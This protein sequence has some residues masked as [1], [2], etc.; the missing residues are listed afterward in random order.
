MLTGMLAAV[1]VAA[2]LPRQ[3]D[4]APVPTPHFPDAL[5]A[6]VW[7]NWQ[8]VEP[9]RL[10]KVLGT[11]AA[12][13]QD[14]AVSMGLPRY[15]VVPA[16]MKER[17]YITLVRRNWHL[18]PLE[19]IMQL[20]DVSAAEMAVKFREDDALSWKL[21]FVRPKCPPVIYHEPNAAARQRAAEIK[22]LVDAR[23][24]DRL[25]RDAEPRF[26]FVAELSGIPTAAPSETLPPDD[27]LRFLYSYFGVYGDPLSA[28]SL[29]PYP[30]GLL[31]R[32]QQCDVNGVW[33][34][35]LLRQLAPGGPLF[36]EFGEG[37]E[38]RLKNLR[39]MVDRARKYNI[40]V[41]LFL[42]EP[43]A[44]PRGFFTD[45]PELAGAPDPLDRSY[46]SICT[47]D[48][49]V[50][51]WYADS[52]SHVFREVP[53][54]GGVFTITASEMQS[55][56]ASHANRAECP[57]CGKR[58]AAEVIAELNGTVEAAVHGV[59][60]HAKV[61]VWDWGWNNHGDASDM[62]AASPL[63]TWLM[64]V[65]EWGVPIRRG[66]VPYTTGEYSL[67]A[68]GPGPRAI[69]HWAAARQ[70]GLKTVAKVQVSNSWELSAVPYLPVYDLVAEHGSRLA[71][72]DIDGQMLSWSLG[73]YPSPNLELAAA[74]SR[75]PTPDK[76]AAIQALATRHFGAA[77]APQVR[78]A[79]KAFSQAFAEFPFGG[80]VVYNAPQQFGPANLLYSTPTG[81]N[82]GPVCFPYDDLAHWSPP[83][84]KQV[85]AAQ[86]QK[87]ADGWN[88]GIA[89]LR[90]AQSEVPADKRAWAQTDLGVAEAAQI[91][92]AST[93]N[94]IRFIL[95]RDACAIAT[96]PA[97]RDRL[98]RELSLLLDDESR[99]ADR[100]FELASK[101]SRLG[102]EA[103]NHYYYVPLDL[104]EKAVSCEYL[105]TQWLAE[106]H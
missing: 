1:A 93:A 94:Q 25:N 86:F 69:R 23:F 38:V 32:Y 70:R 28:P 42:L 72:Q 21:G 6:V 24:G 20:L 41:Y 19:Q 68:V 102:Y 82:C 26:S 49:R 103:S 77:A 89:L 71:G 11:D 64:S 75:T 43:R 88:Q 63:N 106:M 92:F 98:K 9:A 16:Q 31:A 17:G 100:L 13:V 58:S 61:I 81:M 30:E 101:D 54:L 65:S 48:P 79:W 45:R 87:V 47:S 12:K 35:V 78:Q 2:E 62:I 52:L 56:C 10:A 40:Q 55:N 91:H 51:K 67:S 104:V 97:E 3:S 57:R 96:N 37:H 84:P 15:T 66:G 73:G 39:A 90:T 85:L 27:K 83:Y 29:D 105:K 74:F 36:P 8:L 60:P 53:G 5:H 33:L 34:H 22:Q 76:E 44:M 4:R 18:L 99:L 95:A 80:A 7:R 46:V 50:R 14:I 59:D